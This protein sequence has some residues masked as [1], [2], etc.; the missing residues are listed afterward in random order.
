MNQASS[1]ASRATSASLSLC[2]VT[3][4]RTAKTTR[5]RSAVVRA[6]GFCL[7]HTPQPLHDPQSCSSSGTAPTRGS[8]GLQNLTGST[9][10]PGFHHDSTSG[11]P[12]VQ[13]TTFPGGL[14][15]V[16]SPSVKGQPGV[17]LS[18]R[19]FLCVGN[20]KFMVSSTNRPLVD[21]TAGGEH[22]SPWAAPQ[23]KRPAWQ[24]GTTNHPP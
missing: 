15:G 13:G 1:P 9:G 5:T 18:D 19:G 2:C 20:T 22:R 14:P 24:T 3:A 6:D 4:D 10:R 12:G 7:M 23:H 11:A 8:P 17:L 16:A 21:H